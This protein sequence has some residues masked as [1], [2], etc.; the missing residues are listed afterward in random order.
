MGS[1]ASTLVLS[2]EEADTGKH[3]KNN[4]VKAY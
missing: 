3:S 1:C 2:A 4:Q